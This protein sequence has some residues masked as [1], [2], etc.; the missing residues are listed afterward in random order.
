MDDGKIVYTLVGVD[1]VGA[2]TPDDKTITWPD[3]EIWKKVVRDV[4][5]FF[6]LFNIFL[7]N[8]I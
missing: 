7:Q 1:Y 6:F 3:Q 2:L 5:V 8:R 4:C